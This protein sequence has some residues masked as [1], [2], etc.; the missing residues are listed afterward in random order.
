MTEAAL[1]SMQS[2]FPQFLRRADAARYLRDSYGIPCVATTLAKYACVRQSPIPQG[3]KFPIYARD[4]LDAW[5]NDRLGR[6]V[7]S[8]S[9]LA[10]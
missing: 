4:D 9:E 7:R 2:E 1:N 8:T 6:L 5:A 3:G 10:G